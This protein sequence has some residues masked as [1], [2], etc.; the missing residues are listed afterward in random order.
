M[1]RALRVLALPLALA[2]V[3][4]LPGRADAAPSVV[5]P[6][7]AV[8]T[9]VVRPRPADQHG[10]HR[11]QRHVRAREGHRQGAAGRERLGAQHRPRP[12]RE[13]RLRARA[14]RDRPPSA[15]LGERTCLPVLDGDDHRPGHH[16][17]VRHT[18]AREQGRRLLLER[19]DADVRAQHHQAAR[20]AAGRRP[21]ASAGTTT[22]ASSASA[23]T[24]SSTSSMGDTGRRGQLQ[25]LVERAVRPRHPGRPVRRPGARQR[26]SDRRTSSG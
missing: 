4:V 6:D 22:A 8:R 24:R 2:A 23:P 7:L 19:L 5:D 3:F 15:L 16:G 10:V 11:P 12:G 25:N 9:A 1:T 13:Q 14:A 26:A 18:P 17:S 21:T 20:P